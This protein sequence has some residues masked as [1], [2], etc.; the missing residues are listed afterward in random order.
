MI[1]FRSRPLVP[2]WWNWQT[3][4]FEGRVG[5]PVRVRIPPPAPIHH[6]PTGGVEPLA[7]RRLGLLLGRL[8]LLGL[9]ARIDALA[10]GAHDAARRPVDAQEAPARRAAQVRSGAIR[11]HRLLTRVPHTRVPA[12]SR[13]TPREN[14][15]ITAGAPKFF[16]KN[17]AS[18]LPSGMPPRKARP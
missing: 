1:V 12:A 7:A 5:K 2:E 4:T 13:M 9:R 15:P 17:P 6:C 10:A 16:T 8:R 14:T 11:G 18:R 3:R